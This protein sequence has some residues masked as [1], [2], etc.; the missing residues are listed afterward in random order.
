MNKRQ[1]GT[2]SVYQR[3]KMW[4]IRYY[5]QR[6]KRH[7][8]SSHS[9]LRE[10]AERLLRQRLDQPVDRKPTLN[11]ILDQLEWDY[12]LRERNVYKM[13]SHLKPVREHL[14]KKRVADITED[15]IS[16]YQRERLKHVSKSTIN[17]ECQLLGQALKLAYPSIISRPIRIRKLP[18]AAPREDFFEP[19]E[20][21]VVIANLPD[22][23][24]DVTRFGYITSWRKNEI[25]SLRW[26]SVNFA[27]RE[28]RLRPKTVKTR[29]GRVSPLT[30]E[31][32]ALLEYRREMR[33]NELVFHRHGERIHDFRKAWRSA[34]RAANCEGKVFHALRRSAIRNMIRGGTHERVAME[35]SGHKT[36]SIFDRYNIVDTKDMERALTQTGNYTDK[37]RTKGMQVVTIRDGQIVNE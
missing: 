3:G 37:E 22:Y 5:D 4:W 36:R 29:A 9:T 25:L 35:I 23:L 28:I 18:E 20:I 15:V 27:Q 30:D 32:I 31:L 34:T 26:D 6:G 17:R 19:K 13:K 12:E 21:E 7:F 11:D 2:G 8:E 33:V 1:Y 16:R 14:G 10:Q 24:R